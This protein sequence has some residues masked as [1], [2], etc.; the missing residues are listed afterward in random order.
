[1]T[2]PLELMHVR[3]SDF[4]SKKGY[5]NFVFVSESSSRLG[6]LAVAAAALGQSGVAEG[7]LVQSS[8]LE[9]VAY[10]VQF[11][12]NERPATGWLWFAPFNNGDDVDVVAYW[13]KD[14][15]EVVAVARPNDRCIALYP[16]LSRG[17]NAHWKAVWKF[18]F[19]GMSAF[20]IVAYSIAA[21]VAIVTGGFG[22]DFYLAMFI[23]ILIMYVLMIPPAIHIGSQRMKF[24][25]VAERVF[26]VL[27]FANVGEIDLV[28]SS[29]LRRSD[30]L[31]E[32]G[33]FYFR[34]E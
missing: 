8:D 28:K 5:A 31:A 26:T 1:M 16:H 11:T 30:D 2:A 22:Y 24:V 17:T 6:M 14:H 19:W 3:L 34:Y 10:Y 33:T 13:D 7:S 23:P 25:R 21:F 9:E 18:W 32:F 4:K 29:R 27:G 15:Y 20:S 12:M